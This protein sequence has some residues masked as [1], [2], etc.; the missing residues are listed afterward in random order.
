MLNA[1]QRHRVYEMREN[2]REMANPFYL[3]FITHPSDGD[4]TKISSLCELSSFAYKVFSCY[5][6]VCLF[7]PSPIQCD[8]HVARKL[9]DTKHSI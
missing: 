1:L 9:L 8:R 2:E 7:F 3:F 5:I 6:D 4:S